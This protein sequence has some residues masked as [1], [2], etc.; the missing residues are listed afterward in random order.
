VNRTHP[1]TIEP[2]SLDPTN[3]PTF[4]GQA[5]VLDGTSH[6]VRTVLA[7]DGALIDLYGITVRPFPF[8]DSGL[9]A[10]F[11]AT[12]VG[13]GA[14]PAGRPVDVLRSGYIMA[15]IN[16]V[17]VK[18]GGV[19]VW[20]AATAAPHVQGAFETATPGG[21]GFAITGN[22]KT[23]FQGGVDANGIGEIAFNI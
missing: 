3:P 6:K 20:A 17:P 23:T 12:N 10:A 2:A 1:A 19:F 5:V 22:D 4:Y 13:V 18:G 15:P 11:G 21:N 14:L 8:Q 16:G 9:A 7:G